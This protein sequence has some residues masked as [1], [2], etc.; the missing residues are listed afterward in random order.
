MKVQHHGVCVRDEMWVK[1]SRIFTEPGQSACQHASNPQRRLSVHRIK[2][3]TAPRNLP[4]L[5]LRS[6]NLVRDAPPPPK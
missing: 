5:A 3:N 1:E 4:E 2:H 6:G